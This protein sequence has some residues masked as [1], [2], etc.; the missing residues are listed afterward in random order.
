M[1]RHY[2]YIKPLKKE[3]LHDDK[4]K[5]LREKIFLEGAICWQHIK[6]RTAVFRYI[7]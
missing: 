6:G 7:S 3:L 1:P 5:N 2:C 4:N